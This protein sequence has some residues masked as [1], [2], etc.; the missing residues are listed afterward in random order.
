V[1]RLERIN[2]AKGKLE[3]V[4]R[5][6]AYLESRIYDLYEE[7]SDLEFKQSE[8]EEE[9]R[10]LRTTIEYLESDPQGAIDRAQIAI[11]IRNQEYAKQRL[12]ARYGT[13]TPESIR[14]FYEGIKAFTP[15]AAKVTT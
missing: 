9:K 12:I 8:Q 3:D 14:D 2:E 7:I 5:E 4:E 10:E 13:D 11:D 1:N 6:L 15:I